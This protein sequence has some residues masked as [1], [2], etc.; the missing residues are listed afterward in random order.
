M[1]RRI[2]PLALMAL[3]L[4]AIAYLLIP[5]YRP[6][7]AFALKN[8]NGA[9]VSSEQLQGKVTLI[10]FWYP[11]C[12]GCVS[13]MPKLIQMAHDYQSRPNFQIIGIAMPVDPPES[14]QNYVQSRQIPFTVAIDSQNYTTKAYNIQAAPSSFLI[15]AQGRIRQY[16]IGEPDF[17]QLYQSTDTLL[18]E[19]PQP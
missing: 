13:E 17:A 18:N 5:D 9:P 12:P 15:D 14:V 1:K 3:A 11:S 6:A 4:I 10:N 16:F 2:L 8:L 7:P 19:I